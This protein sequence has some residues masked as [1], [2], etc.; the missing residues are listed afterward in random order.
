MRISEPLRDSG[1]ELRCVTQAGVERFGAESFCAGIELC[2]RT[3]VQVGA[4]L[5]TDSDVDRCRVPLV[6]SVQV[7][8]C[9]RSVQV[10]R[11]REW[12]RTSVRCRDPAHPP[13][14]L[15]VGRS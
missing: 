2:C 6:A 5:V 3:L 10:G 9:M 14:A 4:K 11:C 12:C 8:R 15:Q 13:V 7:G 1:A